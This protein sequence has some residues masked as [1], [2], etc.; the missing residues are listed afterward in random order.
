[1]GEGGLAAQGCLARFESVGLV[2]ELDARRHFTTMQIFT[3][4]PCATF[5][6]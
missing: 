4:A 3:E 1:M 5:G 6:L 2:N